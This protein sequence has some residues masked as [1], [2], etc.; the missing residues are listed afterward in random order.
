MAT[1]RAP[2]EGQKERPTLPTVLRVGGSVPTPARFL[3]DTGSDLTIINR[4]TWEKWR[5]KPKALGPPR[6]IGGIGGA[7]RAV[8]AGPAT[9]T[10]L[11][12]GEPVQVRLRRVYLADDPI[13]YCLLGSDFYV[14]AGAVVTFDY[15]D[16]VATLEI[17]TAV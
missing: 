14:E 5:R 1:I 13:P 8:P 16:K 11:A 15:R 17:E 4:A 10:F 3:L 6:K 2:F 12:D 9:L 7:S